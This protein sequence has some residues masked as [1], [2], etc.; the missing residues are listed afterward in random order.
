MHR[1]SF[2]AMAASAL[3]FLGGWARAAAPSKMTV[4][5]D[6][7]CGCCHE[8]SKAMTAAGFSIDLRDT[9]D[10]AAVK[11]RLG[12]PTAVEGCHTAIAEEYYL[13]GHV[14]LEAVQR[15]AAGAAAGPRAGRAGHARLARWGWATTRR[16]PMTSLRSLREPAHHT[17]SSRTAPGRSHVAIDGPRRALKGS[18]EP[19]REILLPVDHAWVPRFGHRNIDRTSAKMIH[20]A[21][22][23]HP[24]VHHRPSPSLSSGW[25]RT[26]RCGR[27]GRGREC[28]LCKASATMDWARIARFRGQ[29]APTLSRGGSKAPISR[30]AAW[31]S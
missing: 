13:E 15:L 19:N 28:G 27:R 29:C 7:N 10:L 5:K 30:P 12:V 20:S 9:G 24:S 11:A 31:S 25:H 14:P 17:Y 6:P 4:Y 2:I 18:P 1:R 23:A 8:W 16:R 22:A 26:N 21:R 3:A